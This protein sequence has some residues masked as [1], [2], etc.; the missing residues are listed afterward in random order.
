MPS[1]EMTGPRLLA[2]SCHLLPFDSVE[3]F[4]QYILRDA[5]VVGIIR[6]KMTPVGIKY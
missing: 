6:K 5:K 3:Y 1:I 4:A 2:R